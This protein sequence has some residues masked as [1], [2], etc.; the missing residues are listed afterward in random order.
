MPFLPFR[1]LIFLLIYIF[2]GVCRQACKALRFSMHEMQILLQESSMLIKEL[3]IIISDFS[4]PEYASGRLLR[5]G[6]FTSR[7]AQLAHKKCHRYNWN[8]HLLFSGSMDPAVIR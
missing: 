8:P 4:F 7:N 1:Q 3:P 6:A 2:Y 5:K